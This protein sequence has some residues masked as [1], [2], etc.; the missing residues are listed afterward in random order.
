MSDNIYSVT[1]IYGSSRE[2]IDD[3]IRN[4]VQTAGETVHNTEWFQVSEIRGHI[5][6]GKVAHF[7]VGVKIGFRYE[8]SK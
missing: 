3:A 7:Q 2:S 1:E 6:D 5:E 4:A 8:R